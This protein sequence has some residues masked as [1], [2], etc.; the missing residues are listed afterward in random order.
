MNIEPDPGTSRIRALYTRRRKTYAAYVQAFGHRQG[1]QAALEASSYLRSGQR[2]LDVG[3]GSGLSILA[4]VDALRK[5]AYDYRSI[6]A[7]DLTPAMLELCRQTMERHGIKGV[8]LREADV[9]RL[10]EQLPANWS[11]YDLALCAS[12]LEYVPDAALV[13]VLEA[14]R[15]RL[16]PSGRLLVIVTRRSFL[17]TQ[18]IWHCSG[19]TRAR[20]ETAFHEAGFQH[21]HFHH[22]PWR[23]GWLNVA[24][25]LVWAANSG[26][27]LP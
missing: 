17:P 6:Q 26:N 11:G 10:D 16:A 13:P 18:W 27:D 12:M 19:Y 7:F 21:A 24:D 20:L 22:Y 2:I 15:A 25:H 3:C 23:F 1:I 4:I 9:T 14:L 5:R 8:E